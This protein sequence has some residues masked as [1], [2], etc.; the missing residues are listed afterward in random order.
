MTRLLFGERTGGAGQMFDTLQVRVYNVVWS[1]EGRL[2][3]RGSVVKRAAVGVFVL[4]VA[5]CSNEALLEAFACFDP[6]NCPAGEAVPGFPAG[7]AQPLAPGG[8]SGSVG[9]APVPAAFEPVI[10][11]GGDSADA[12]DRQGL[13]D[14]FVSPFLGFDQI[15]GLFASLLDVLTPGLFDSGGPRLDDS[16]TVLQRLCEDGDRPETFCRSRFGH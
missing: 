3:W 6:A 15:P 2:G 7:L 4:C 13:F 12:I 5:G 9:A 1:G 16:V 8:V 10:L 11:P 14:P